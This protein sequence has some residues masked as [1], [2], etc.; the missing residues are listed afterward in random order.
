MAHKFDKKE[1]LRRERDILNKHRMAGDMQNDLDELLNGVD[2]P[3]GYHMMPDS[4][5]MANEDMEQQP[6]DNAQV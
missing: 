3:A 5:L 2:V 6:D 4:T 1:F